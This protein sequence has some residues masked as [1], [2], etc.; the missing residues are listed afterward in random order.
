M[1]KLDDLTVEVS[2]R[3]TISEDTAER[4]LR[5]L[6]MYLED[7]QDRKVEYSYS[8]GVGP[9]LQITARP[10]LSSQELVRAVEEGLRENPLKHVPACCGGTI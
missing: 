7:H 5:L 6:E 3:L 1:A 10:T 2:A 4:C 9:K 8:P